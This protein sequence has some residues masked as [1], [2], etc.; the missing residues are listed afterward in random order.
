M[1][2]ALKLPGLSPAVSQIVTH[3]LSVF[4]VAF[5][6][7][8]GAA[9]NGNIRDWPTLLALVLAAGVAG[10]VAVIHFLVGLIPT[11]ASLVK[12]PLAQ[13]VWSAV[14]VF[15][16]TLGA[17]LAVGASRVVSVP[18]FVAVSTA[19]ITAAAAAVLHYGFKLIPTPVATAGGKL[20][21]MHVNVHLVTDLEQF[22]KELLPELEKLFRRKAAGPAKKAVK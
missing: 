16:T 18:T 19:A 6:A 15:A 9:A 12:N 8:V 2:T 5:L 7:Q 22:A 21:T 20:A 4:T 17:Q 10:V 11:P 3:V 14:T 1:R 13:V